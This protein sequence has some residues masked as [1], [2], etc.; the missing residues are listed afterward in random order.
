MTRQA[1]TMSLTRVILAILLVET[2]PQTETATVDHRKLCRQT[3]ISRWPWA[4]A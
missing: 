1:R 3:K 4:T 2:D